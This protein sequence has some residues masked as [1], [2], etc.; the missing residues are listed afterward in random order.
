M[1]QLK[2][3]LNRI[4][5]ILVMTAYVG[6]SPTRTRK[7]VVMAVTMA[8]IAAAIGQVRI[9]WKITAKWELQQN[10]IRI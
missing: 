3:H 10:V 7:S 9:V 6:S 4:I 2:G 5:V 1:K 8:A